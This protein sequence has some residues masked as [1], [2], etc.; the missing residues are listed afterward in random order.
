MLFWVNW[1]PTDSQ[2]QIKDNTTSAASSL[3][4]YISTRM[5]PPFGGKG[6]GKRKRGE[7]GRDMPGEAPCAQ[8]IPSPPSS[9]PPLGPG[10]PPEIPLNVF[11]LLSSQLVISCDCLQMCYFLFTFHHFSNVLLQKLQVFKCLRSFKMLHHL[12]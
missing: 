4:K 10:N 11:F 5:V 2:H 12:R 9:P 6:G 8:R 3:Q 7:G 1:N